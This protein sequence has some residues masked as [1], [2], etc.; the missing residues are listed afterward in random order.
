MT[1]ILEGSLEDVQF[2]KTKHEN[3]RKLSESALMVL[4]CFKERPELRLKPKEIIET[5]R[6]PRRT[7]SYV[8]ADLAEK[9]FL[10]KYGQRAGIRYQLVF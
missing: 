7:V 10:Q 1:K 8:L 5:T 9:R 2:Y 4:S 6:L 3:F